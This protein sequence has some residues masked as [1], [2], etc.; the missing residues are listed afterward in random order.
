MSWPV[1]LAFV[2]AFAGGP[3]LYSVLMR[4]KGGALVTL[5]IGACVV[6][7]AV[8]AMW[9]TRRPDLLRPVPGPLAA[10]FSMWLAWVLAIAMTALALRPRFTTP[11]GRRALYLTGILA[12]TLPWFGLATARLMTA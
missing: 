3:A 9:V 11:K 1:I 6:G 10:L 7:F 4:L 8:L 2:A 5:G 12:T